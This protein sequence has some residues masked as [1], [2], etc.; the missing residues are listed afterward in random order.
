MSAPYRAT[1]GGVEQ[2]KNGFGQLGK[3]ADHAVRPYVGD[4]DLGIAVVYA[5]DRDAC[6]AGGRNVAQGVADHHRA[7]RVAGGA[8]DRA[9][10]QFRVRLLYSEGVGSADGDEA[11]RETERIEEPPRQAFELVRAH[12]EPV[13]VSGEC[14]EGR[15]E[16]GKRPRLIRDVLGIVGDEVPDQSVELAGGKLAALGCQS[17]LD[18]RARAAADH[19]ACGIVAERRQA[20]AAEDDVEGGDQIGRGIDQRPVEIENDGGSNHD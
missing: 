9:A 6:P 17:A 10:Q 20:F 11:V 4:R 2:G 18:N 19:V 3:G 1:A 5:D 15:L 8:D 13:S 14:V 12:R 7:P 16:A